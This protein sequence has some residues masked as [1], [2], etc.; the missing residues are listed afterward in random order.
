M[1]LTAS[2]KKIAVTAAAISSI[3]LI[4]FLLINFILGWILE[5]RIDHYLLTKANRKYHISIHKASVNVLTGTL[6]LKN[7]VVVPDSTYLEAYRQGK[8]KAGLLFSVEVPDFKL[9]DFKWIQMLK[10]KELIVD[11]IIVEHPRLRIYTNSRQKDKERLKT[12]EGFA[13]TSIDSIYIKNVNAIKLGGIYF[14]QCAFSMYDLAEQKVT[15][16]NN[17]FNFSIQ[18]IH[19]EELEGEADFFRL[20]LEPLSLEVTDEV[21]DFPGGWYQMGFK[22]LQYSHASQAV[23]VDDLYMK[24]RYDDLFK[25]AAKRPFRDAI[26][27]VMIDSL[28]FDMPDIRGIISQGLFAVNR[29]GVEGMQMDVFMDKHQPQDEARRPKMPQQLLR[30]MHLPIYI[31]QIDISNSTLAYKERPL[32]KT[33]LLQIKFMDLQLVIKNITSIRDS[34]KRMDPMSIKFSSNFMGKAP[35][36]LEFLLPLNSRVDTF[37]FNGSL[38]SAKMELFNPA[39]MPALGVKF[40]EGNLKKLVFNANASRN[41]AAGEM[42]MLYDELEAVVIDKEHKDADKLLSWVANK[43]VRNANPGKNGVVRSVPMEFERV[44]YKGFVNLVWKTIQS[45]IVNTVSPVGKTITEDKKKERK[46]FWQ[47]KKKS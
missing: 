10:T 32:R 44:P 33:E 21:F 6:I 36:K 43:L 12:E 2:Q 4:L 38:G 18:G 37:F 34:L 42:T 25:M 39:V 17:H 23:L 27:T 45:G 30:S 28:R 35:L 15:L 14:S 26:F 29:I 20:N 7:V 11:E 16:E 41:K 5:N 47:K 24:P 3:L 1:N 8:L 19:F 9:K 22:S 13:Q 46:W 31:K 40:H